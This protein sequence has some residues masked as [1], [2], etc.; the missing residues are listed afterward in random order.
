[1]QKQSRSTLC[2]A[3]CYILLELAVHL[4]IAIAKKEVSQILLL[5]GIDHLLLVTAQQ[6]VLV[7]N[8]ELCSFVFLQFWGVVANSCLTSYLHSCGEAITTNCIAYLIVLT[9]QED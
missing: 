3:I 7:T 6:S 1:M 9:K 5:N 2:Q 4:C 8:I